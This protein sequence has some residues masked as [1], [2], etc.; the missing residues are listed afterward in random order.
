LFEMSFLSLYE[1]KRKALE[2]LR[3]FKLIADNCDREATGKPLLVDRRREFRKKVEKI[4]PFLRK[5][6]IPSSTNTYERLFEAGTKE[7]DIFRLVLT[8]IICEIVGIL[9]CITIAVKYSTFPSVLGI[10]AG[11]GT[12][13]VLGFMIVSPTIRAVILLAIPKLV[14]SKLRAIFLLFLISWSF[15]FPAM[16]TVENLQS[17]AI[18]IAC[19]RSSVIQVGND[20]IEETNQQLNKIRLIFIEYLLNIYKLAQLM[21]IKE[22]CQRFFIGPYYFVRNFYSSLFFWR[23]LCMKTFEEASVKCDEHMIS[24]TNKICSYIKDLKAVCAVARFTEQ[25]CVIPDKIKNTLKLGF[26]SFIKDKAQN[27][28][29]SA[30]DALNVTFYVALKYAVK[31]NNDEKT[32]NFY[33]TDEFR[34]IDLLREARNEPAIL[35]LLP[36]EEKKYLDGFKL[37]ML[38][39]EKLKLTF[40]LGMTLITGFVPFLLVMIDVFT[41]ELLNYSY[42]FFQSNLTQTDRLDHYELAISGEGFAANLMKKILQIFNPITRGSDIYASRLRRIIANHYWPERSKPRALFLYNQLLL[43]RKLLLSD[44]IKRAKKKEFKEQLAHDEM[45]GRSNLINRGLPIIRGD[46]DQC[47]RCGCFNLSAIAASN[48][49][50]CPNCDGLYCTDCY[51]VRKRCLKCHTNMKNSKKY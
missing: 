23:S 39:K 33:I 15:Q 6:P 12:Q 10:Y 50:M 13:I 43:A 16:N 44:V 40:S 8:I 28:V 1:Q 38:A 47:I 17:L 22:M 31:Y 27:T 18:S 20:I 36:E 29:K 4:F 41:Y 5:P 48:S 24:F 21:L 9:F 34:K 11:I 32:D 2:K 26:L 30:L 37:H 3:Q 46:E 51:A 19:I 45:A 7:N 14:T 49:R 25:V 35:P 42:E